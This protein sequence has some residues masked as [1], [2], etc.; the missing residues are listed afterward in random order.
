MHLSETKIAYLISS[1]AAV[2]ACY[3]SNKSK[4]HTMHR[5]VTVASIFN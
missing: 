3:R 5:L 2:R 4:Q 1:S